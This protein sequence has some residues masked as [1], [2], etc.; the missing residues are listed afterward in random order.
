MAYAK[1]FYFQLLSFG[2]IS[3]K[4]G[5]NEPSSIEFEEVGGISEVEIN[6]K[7]NGIPIDTELL[8]SLYEVHQH[9]ERFSNLEISD[10][11]SK[12]NM[13]SLLTNEQLQYKV[14]DLQEENQKINNK[15]KFSIIYL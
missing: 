13:M 5:E 4:K 6:E 11:F 9:R 3:H 15:V 2:E 7:N 14:K 12:D 10:E 1:E 8:K